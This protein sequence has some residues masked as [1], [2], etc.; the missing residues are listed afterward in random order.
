MVLTLRIDPSDGG[1]QSVGRKTLELADQAGD[2]DDRRLGKTYSP[3]DH[4]R[5]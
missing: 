4:V 3:G 2:L 5:G 1:E